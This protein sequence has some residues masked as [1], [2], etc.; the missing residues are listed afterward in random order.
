MKMKSTLISEFPVLTPDNAIAQEEIL[1]KRREHFL[2]SRKTMQEI[3]AKDSVDHAPY[4]GQGSYLFL[5]SKHP[6]TQL[7]VTSH[8]K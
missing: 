5:G 6:S 1:Y 4:L 3:R 2:E 7:P 8:V